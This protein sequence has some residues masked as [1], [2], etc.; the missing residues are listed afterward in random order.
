MPFRQERRCVAVTMG[1]HRPTQP[2]GGGSRGRAIAAARR[3]SS[4]QRGGSLWPAALAC[5]LVAAVCTGT[6]EAQQCRFKGGHCP[7]WSQAEKINTEWNNPQDGKSAF[8]HQRPRAIPCS[9]RYQEKREARQ[10]VL[11]GEVVCQCAGEGRVPRG[12]KTQKKGL[13]WKT[14]EEMH[15]VALVAGWAGSTAP[16]RA[17]S[18]SRPRGPG[19][20][21]HAAWL[22]RL[23]LSLQTLST[24]STNNAVLDITS[25]RFA[26]FALPVG[27]VCD[28][29]RPACRP[30]CPGL[31]RITA[32][33]AVC[34]M[35]R[36]GTS[37][38]S[39]A[40]PGAA[41]PGPVY[42][43]HGRF[44]L[45]A[46]TQTRA[47]PIPTRDAPERELGTMAWRTAPRQT[48]PAARCLLPAAAT[49]RG[50]TN[51]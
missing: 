15:V 26:I 27:R 43:L 18:S 5:A 3:A 2:E 17:R 36:P 23:P 40:R 12:R 13:R 30:R 34:W 4:G 49:K 25:I 47:H 45:T 42:I 38:S 7:S 33:V 44:P 14:R 11:E 51:H 10:G 31:H 6:C 1:A 50:V 37:T 22:P 29:T 39:R 8:W 35:A 21:A 19:L 9:A 24:G 32:D 20:M 46:L 16:L 48:P 41:E 28:S